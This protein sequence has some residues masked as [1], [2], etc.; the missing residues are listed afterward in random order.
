MR[1]SAFLFPGQ[2]SQEI[3]MGYDLFKDD[4]YFRSLI[5][6][7]DEIT[8]ENLEK[9]C[10]Q[11]PDRVLM[12]AGI[13]QPALVCICL[14]YLRRLSERGVTADFILG[15]S[16]GEITSLA[17]SGVVS[18]EDAIRIA[19]KRG[20][21]MDQVASGCN[22]GMLAVMFVPLGDVEQLLREF[23]APE[24]I[25]FA[26]DNAPDQV[27]LSGDLE[28]LDKFA[29]VISE[30]KLGKC[31]KVPVVGP[32]HS[33]FMSKAR[34]E[35][36][37]WAESIAFKKPGIS[38]ILNATSKTETHPATIKHLVS[39]Q[40][41]SPVF[42]RKSMDLIRESGVDTIYEIGPGRVLSGLARVNGFKKN[43]TIYN[44][45]TLSGID[46]VQLT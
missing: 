28:Y 26:N 18:D 21:L 39:W 44:I 4:A 22:G 8:G 37:E 10:L 25:V 23:E 16:L 32:W 1:K 45:N 15:H 31:K 6:L 5:S 7:A 34:C 38:L 12:Q 33:P 11:G 2:G 20:E 14:G 29:S 17:A 13:L 36:E 30:R 35:F 9:I 43:T 19:A 24:K 41:T 46:S 42:W 40:L 27:V 3:G